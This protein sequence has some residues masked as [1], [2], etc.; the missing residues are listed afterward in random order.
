MLRLLTLFIPILISSIEATQPA[1]PSKK[2]E[3]CQKQR[4]GDDKFSIG[5]AHLCLGTSKTAQKHKDCAE[6]FHPHFCTPTPK[7]GYEQ[8]CKIVTETL[9]STENTQNPPSNCTTANCKNLQFITS[10]T[11]KSCLADTTAA[12]ANLD[13]SKAFSAKFCSPVQKGQE[14]TCKIVQEVLA[15]A[16]NKSTPSSPPKCPVEKCGD[17][18]FMTPSQAKACFLSVDEAKKNLDCAKAFYEK[19][20][21][22]TMLKD[23]LPSCQTTGQAITSSTNTSNTG[24]PLTSNTNKPNT[25]QATPGTNP[26]PNQAASSSNSPN[27]NCPAEKCGDS[28]FMTV[29]QANTCFSSVD[30]AKKNLACAKTFQ[31]KL[32]SN[33]TLKDY[34]P[35]CQNAAKALTSSGPSQAP[36]SESAQPSSGSPPSPDQKQPTKNTPL[37]LT[38]GQ[39]NGVISYRDLSS[40]TGSGS[41]RRTGRITASTSDEPEEE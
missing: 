3:E 24:Q 41:S 32:C 34:T 30:E 16:K 26:D 5:E 37:A 13:C 6:V 8:P 27:P 9:N 4:C 39:C 33:T 17:I 31:E 38:G 36:S 35:S 11:G 29:S 21:G 28:Q 22:N 14:N 19:L 7:R 25:G 20:C 12:K 10:Q 23:Y 1:Q 18:V 40:G 2:S 15:P